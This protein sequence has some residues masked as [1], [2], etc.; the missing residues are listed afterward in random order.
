MTLTNEELADD[1]PTYF[2]EQVKCDLDSLCKAT[3]RSIDEV[4]LITHLVLREIT[5]KDHGIQKSTITFILN[6]IVNLC[7]C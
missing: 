7:K 3:G 2:W 4:A 5:Q 6:L 1:I